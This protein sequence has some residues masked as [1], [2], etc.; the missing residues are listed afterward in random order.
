MA[1]VLTIIRQLFQPRLCDVTAS[2]PFLLLASTRFAH[3]VSD[4][5]PVSTDSD[6]QVDLTCATR[7]AR[8]AV[9]VRST[10]SE[11]TQFRFPP[12]RPD[13][14]G[15]QEEDEKH[16]V[17]LVL[18]SGAAA[19]LLPWSLL[20]V[21]SRPDDFLFGPVTTSERERERERATIVLSS[22][23]TS[24]GSG[25]RLRVL[26]THKHAQ[27][28]IQAGERPTTKPLSLHT[29]SIVEMS[30]CKCDKR[31]HLKRSL[32]TVLLSCQGITKAHFRNVTTG[33][34]RENKINWVSTVIS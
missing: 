6:R 14:P 29:D 12:Q 16:A 21:T 23:F 18:V 4:A 26:C 11:P 33:Q 32:P 22:N 19:E 34:S 8:N 5:S 24:V 9:R 28:C 3:P 10:T 31:S 25:C 2:Y 15:Q 30:S 20:R 17:Y 7:V 27:T 13:T 1:L